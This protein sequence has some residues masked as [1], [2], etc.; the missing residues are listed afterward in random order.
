MLSGCASMSQPLPQD[1]SQLGTASKNKAVIF[2][3]FIPEDP[4]MSTKMVRL[5]KSTLN[6]DGSVND[7]SWLTK[8]NTILVHANLEPVHEYFIFVVDPTK[9]NE[10]WYV[11]YIIQKQKNGTSAQ[12]V[13]FNLDSCDGIEGLDNIKFEV[14]APGV[15]D[16]GIISY[17]QNISEIGEVSFSYKHSYATDSLR[18]YFSEQFPQLSD[19][20]INK[21]SP[22]KYVDKTTCYV[23]G[24]TTIYI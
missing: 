11:P 23:P 6:K 18:V 20:V 9:K 16:L 22:S 24:P 12:D 4:A 2:V 14:N 13:E 3:K 19:K 21:L 17:G 10:T 8:G 1:Y 5:H 7:S 15:Y